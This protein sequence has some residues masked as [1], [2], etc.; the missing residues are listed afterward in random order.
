M[1]FILREFKNTVSKLNKVLDD[2]GV[3]SESVST[4]IANFSSVLTSVKT[5]VSILKLFQ[6]KMHHNESTGGKQRGE[7]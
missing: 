6:K 1:F 2:A 3:I 5:G 4:P 7:K